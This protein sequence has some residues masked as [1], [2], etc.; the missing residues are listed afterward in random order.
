MFLG[1]RI[2]A[3]VGMGQNL[4][5]FFVANQ[6]ARNLRGAMWGYTPPLSPFCNFPSSILLFIPTIPYTN[7]QYSTD[8]TINYLYLLLYQEELSHLTDSIDF[9]VQ[10]L[11][12]LD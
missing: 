9:T 7:R 12:I 1:A 4:G 10:P 11:N 2:E 3:C 5:V 8:V 6:G